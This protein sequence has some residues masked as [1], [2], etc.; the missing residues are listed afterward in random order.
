MSD[1]LPLIEH[2][3][4]E[5]HDQIHVYSPAGF[6]ILAGEAPV[7][8]DDDPIESAA[9]ALLAGFDEAIARNLWSGLD[10]VF[11]SN[12]PD[13]AGRAIQILDEAEDAA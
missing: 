12:V 9:K 3:R 2:E 11:R 10:F 4:T 5:S 13:A 7:R 8:E 6:P 1:R